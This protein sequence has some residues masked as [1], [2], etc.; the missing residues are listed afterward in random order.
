MFGG[1]VSL[2]REDYG[3]L[4]DL[5][6]KQIAAENRESELTVEISKLKKENEQAA[7][8]IDA[9]KQEILRIYPLKEELRKAKNELSILNLKLQKVLGQHRTINAPLPQKE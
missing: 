7:E 5:A 2:S 6:R 3:A 8:Q 9:Q 1:K 4:T